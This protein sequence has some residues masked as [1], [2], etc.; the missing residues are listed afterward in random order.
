MLPEDLDGAITITGYLVIAAAFLFYIIPVTLERVDHHTLAFVA[1]VE[2]ALIVIAFLLG[3][4][5]GK[6][7][8][9]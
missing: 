2:T 3:R 4:V 7:G 1:S 8:R 6:R 5:I 9:G